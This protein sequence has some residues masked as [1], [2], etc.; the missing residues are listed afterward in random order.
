M[1]VSIKDFQI[2]KRAELEF[3]PGLNVVVGP[4]NNGKSAIFRAIK[5]AIFNYPGTTSVRI[6]ASDYYVGIESN[7]H[8]VVYKKGTSTSYIIDGKQ[9]NKPGRSQLPEV[10]RALGIEALDI[11][12]K[13]EHLNFWDQ[14]DKP[15]LLDRTPTELFRFIV[16]SGEDE[17]LTKTLK[18]MV[19]D[20]QSHSVNLTITEGKLSEVNSQRKE[21]EEILKDSE[22]K[23][24]VVEDILNLENDINKLDNIKQIKKSI[25]E[26]EP[27]L[28][29]LKQELSEL[30]NKLKSL[31]GIETIQSDIEQLNT[32]K[33]LLNKIQEHKTNKSVLEQELQNIPD[34][35]SDISSLESILT[36][37]NTCRE[38][39]KSIKESRNSIALL[40]ES[41]TPLDDELISV[42]NELAKFKVCP[43]C[44]QPLGE[45]V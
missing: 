28:N 30:E 21:L 9:Y 34:I 14:M 35:D 20:K 16:D 6:G 26:H 1:K 36:K 42:K 12:N 3:I 39:F 27:K 22:V 15:F 2:I 17:N 19:Q 23:K 13:L 37:L 29:N 38:L 31:E 33:Q 43:T 5:S 8:K 25:E 4:S 40:E 10:A 45:P 18:D 44:G 11:N 32:S 41:L 24:K 7:G